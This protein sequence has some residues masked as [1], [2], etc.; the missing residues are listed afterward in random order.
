M[1]DLKGDSTHVEKKARRKKLQQRFG[2]LSAVVL[3]PVSPASS[4]YGRRCVWR[5]AVGR[6]IA[7]NQC[8]DL[9]DELLLVRKMMQV[10]PRASHCS[11]IVLPFVRA[12]SI[13]KEQ[14]TPRPE[15]RSFLKEDPHRPRQPL[16][17]ETKNKAGMV[18]QKISS[19]IYGSFLL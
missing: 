1:E 7:L 18:V 5:S 8:S 9:I 14:W 12:L 2:D 17:I 3:T 15:V 16:E 11:A 6:L 19:S 4:T 10:A 13:K